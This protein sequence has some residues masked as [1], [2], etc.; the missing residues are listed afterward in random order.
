VNKNLVSATLLA[1]ALLMSAGQALG[2]PPI[3]RTAIGKLAVKGYDCV[4][5]FEKGKAEKGSKDFSQKHKGAVWRFST[6]KHLEMFQK[7]PKKYAPQ[8][9]GYYA[10]A[11]SQGN[12]A[13]IN[14]K[15]WKTV[16]GKRYLNFSKSIQA[17][18]GKD[19]P[20]NIA[21]A[22]KIWPTLIDE[23]KEKPSTP[24]KKQLVEWHA[25]ELRRASTRMIGRRITI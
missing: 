3:N 17:K 21:K 2:V 9:G 20:G 14:P 23:K 25:G 10:W 1:A 19:I 8:Y 16:K 13:K 4:S 12:T 15:S 24:P 11:V 7:N 5:Y 22:D 18:W 6:R